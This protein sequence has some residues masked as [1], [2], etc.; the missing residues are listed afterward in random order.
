MSVRWT[1]VMNL[2]SVIISPEAIPAHVNWDSLE[3]EPFA[4][5][6][7]SVAFWLNLQCN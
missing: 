5:V 7:T 1:Y 6:R 2:L 3:M 4:L